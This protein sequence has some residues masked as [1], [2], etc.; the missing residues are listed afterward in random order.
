VIISGGIDF[1]VAGIVTV[2]NVL[3]AGIAMGRN[4]L[5]LPVVLLCLSIGLFVGALNA[6]LIIRL[7]VPPIIA[8]LGTATMLRGAALIY[9]SEPIGLVTRSL[10]YYSQGFFGPLPVSTYIIVTILTLGFVLLYKTAFGRHLYAVGGD[11]EIAKL[12]GISVFRVRAV[13]YLISGFLAALTGLYLVGRMGSGEPTIGPGLEFDSI[14]AVLLGGAVLGG[15]RGS[16]VGTIAGSLVLV[17]LSNV[18]N[19]IGIQYYFQEITKGFI[20]IL[21]VAIFRQKS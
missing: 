4:E 15:G 21:A 13:A 12:S 7:R 10:S 14:A 18:F 1:S 9:T 5:T 6:I 2:T 20:I 19:Q 3:A 16:L 11:E 8:T 17:L